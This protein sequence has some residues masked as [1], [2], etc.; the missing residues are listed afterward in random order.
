MAVIECFP[1]ASDDVVSDAWPLLRATVPSEAEPSK[2]ST[3]PVAVDGETVAVKVTGR[4]VLDGL[5]LDANVV[6]VGSVF[7]ICNSTG[8]VLPVWVS[9]PL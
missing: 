6:V 7:T 5:S 3:V 2:N 4:P 9:S 8:D 1:A